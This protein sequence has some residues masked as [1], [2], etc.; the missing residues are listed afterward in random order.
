M[1]VTGPLGPGFFLYFRS[2]KQRGTFSG[3]NEG[4]DLVAEMAGK[5]RLNN[6]VMAIILAI[7]DEL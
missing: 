6:D 7:E 3:I 4:P 5:Q 2:K 1:R